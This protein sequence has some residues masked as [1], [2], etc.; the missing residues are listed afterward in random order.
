MV[1]DARRLGY[2]YVFGLLPAN[3][4]EYQFNDRHSDGKAMTT[5]VMV[6]IVLVPLIAWRIYSRV[7]RLIGRQRSKAWRHWCAAI[8]FPLLIALLG[9]GALGSLFASVALAVGLAVGIGLAV[10]GLR[11]TKFEKTELGC[12]YTPNVHIGIALSV[13]FMARVGFR[14]VQMAALTGAEAQRA[15]QD[16]GRSPLTLVIIG[17]MA[18]YYA[19]YAIGLLRW[20]AAVTASSGNAA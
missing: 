11:L 1:I 17:T 15:T 3:P 20:R 8:F 6:M 19:C 9:L 5:S 2:Y 18:G 4:A 12:F 14:L 10:W 16:F 13:V 7:R